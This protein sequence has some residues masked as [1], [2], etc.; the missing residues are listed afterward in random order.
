MKAQ[1]LALLNEKTLVNATISQP[2]QKS[3]ELKRVKLKPIEIRGIYTIQ[4]EYQYERILKHENISI[5]RLYM[6]TSIY[7]LNSFA[8]YMQNLQSKH[9]NTTIKEK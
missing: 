4:L 1:F 3:N 6:Q 7:Y 2:R 8:K 5:R 9:S